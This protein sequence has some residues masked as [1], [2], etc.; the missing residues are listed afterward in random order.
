[1]T[2]LKSS[3]RGIALRHQFRAS[4]LTYCR[5]C[6]VSVP[7]HRIIPKNR[8]RWETLLFMLLEI[9]RIPAAMTRTESIAATT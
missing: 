6:F 8:V 4:L 9:I 7:R 2:R 1:M 3:P 5:I